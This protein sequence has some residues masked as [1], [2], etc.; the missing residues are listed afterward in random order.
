MNFSSIKERIEY[1][2][3][4]I[5]ECEEQKSKIDALANKFLSEQIKKKDFSYETY[6]KELKKLLKGKTRAEWFAY[7]NSKIKA[8]K[9]ELNKLKQ[10]QRKLLR[11]RTVLVVSVNLLVFAFVIPFLLTNYSNFNLTGFLVAEPALVGQNSS[12]NLTNISPQIE[13]TI[14]QTQPANESLAEEPQ[15]KTKE[16]PKPITSSST[17]GSKSSSSSEITS[18]LQESNETQTNQTQT[19]ETIAEPANKSINL[20]NNSAVNN[21][22]F[23]NQSNQTQSVINI[24][25]QSY[26]N[27]S[28][29][30]NIS[31]NESFNQSEIIE[32]Q[33][34]L[35][36]LSETANKTANQTINLTNQTNL[37]NESLE[38]ATIEN[39]TNASLENIS[40]INITNETI[41]QNQTNMTNLSNVSLIENI[42]NITK[43]SIINQS[44]LNETNV[45]K[46]INETLGNETQI[47]KTEVNESNTTSTIINQTLSFFFENLTVAVNSTKAI[48]LEEY[49]NSSNLTYILINFDSMNA[50]IIDD[51]LVISPK[52]VGSFRLKIIASAENYTLE[53]NVFYV[54]SLLPNETNQSTLKNITNETSQE[55]GNIKN[56]TLIKPLPEITLVYP[57]NVILNLSQYFKS[58]SDIIFTFIYDTSKLNVKEKLGVINISSKLND[59]F[60]LTIKIWASDNNN[61]LQNNLSITVLQNLSLLNQIMNLT[62]QS[63]NLTNASLENLSEINLSKVNEPP[64]LLYNL[65]NLTVS[66]TTLKI[67]LSNLFYDP[68]SDELSF[69][70]ISDYP[71]VSFIDSDYLYLYAEHSFNGSR[72]LKLLAS[73]GINVTIVSFFVNYSETFNVSL[74]ENLTNDINHSINVS[75]QTLLNLTS[76]E[77]QESLKYFININGPTR[78]VKRVRVQNSEDAW[79]YKVVSVLIPS[80]AKNITVLFNSQLLKFIDELE[81]PKVKVLSSANDLTTYMQQTNNTQEENL[82][83]NSINESLINSS[84]LQNSSSNL[85]IIN[86]TNSSETNSLENNSNNTLNNTLQE[87]EDNLLSNVV[88]TITGFFGFGIN[89]QINAT[90]ETNLASTNN[91]SNAVLG[92]TNNLVNTTSLNDSQTQIDETFSKEAVYSLKDSELGKAVLIKDYFDPNSIKE[93]EIQYFTLGVH[94]EKVLDY[95]TNLTHYQKFKLTNLDNATYQNIRLTFIEQP[96][97]QLTVLSNSEINYSYVELSNETKI[98]VLV[99]ELKPYETIDLSIY[100]MFDTFSYKL[101]SIINNTWRFDLST[102]F[103]DT[104]ELNL[105]NGSLT[106]DDIVCLDTNESVLNSGLT[107]SVT[108]TETDNSIISEQNSLTNS[109]ILQQENQTENI[110]LNTA[111]AFNNSLENTSLN[112]TTNQTTVNTSLNTFDNET[113]INET[114]QNQEV[115]SNLD[116][117]GNY[118]KF[119][120]TVCKNFAVY[121]SGDDIK[122]AEVQVSFLNSTKEIHSVESKTLF[123]QISSIT[124]FCNNCGEDKLFNVSVGCV[125]TNTA[126]G[127]WDF[128]LQMDFNFSSNRLLAYEA[129]LCVDTIY[130]TDAQDVYAVFL[131]TNSTNL[132]EYEIYAL[133]N[134]KSLDVF[135]MNKPYLTLH[136]NSSIN[137]FSNQTVFCGTGYNIPLS[138]NFRILLLGQD[139]QYSARPFACFMTNSKNT[140]LKIKY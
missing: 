127:G 85:T 20:E 19:N 28:D 46:L 8:Y 133:N 86:G 64:R 58:S 18:I 32:N 36:N 114:M 140:Y 2:N 17:S 63:T 27:I 116:S 105:L 102:E 138:K 104:F 124:G 111:S 31:S 134:I 42:T 14:N 130:S 24:T 12:T 129:T 9:S 55:I 65:T 48:N 122:N 7:L 115:K 118:V 120:T 131:P 22:S 109:T 62:N 40:L 38:N 93:Y 88:Q 13:A 92:S 10:E 53:S 113:N 97:D 83:N 121:L 89:E 126:E 16:S 33:S 106:L 75:N 132:T 78:W 67:K 123:P 61:T 74:P 59:N 108:T 100:A 56:L 81:M 21:E 26:E 72:E 128:A 23:L 34:V 44:V 60:N 41:I 135:L 71:L 35:E 80:D 125:K 50:Q 87:S 73:D 66:N 43:G 79:T 77:Q 107:Q 70:A 137:E 98:L 69:L 45:S 49:F 57:Q 139:M 30:T 119:D 3:R 112:Q 37:T 15:T 5:E 136:I 6:E 90:N 99:K 91:E 94:L 25:N 51:V 84:T 29:L 4:K 117:S 1:L 110:T 39:L 47:N 101:Y 76:K 82:S 68:D 103:N 54:E 11:K 96:L 52:T 95:R